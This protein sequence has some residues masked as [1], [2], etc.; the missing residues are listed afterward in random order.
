MSLNRY[1][2]TV[3][4]YWR[5]QPDEG[6][7][8]QSKVTELSRSVPAPLELARRLDRELREYVVERTPHVAELRN[9]G[10][11]GLSRVSML[12]LAEYLLRLWVP[13]PKPRKRVDAD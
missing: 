1:E 4:D 9:L 10:A 11:A 2:Q 5:R 7:H 8:W 3:F 13:P 6:R 12:N